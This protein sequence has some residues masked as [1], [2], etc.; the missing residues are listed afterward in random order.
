MKDCMKT[1][2]NNFLLKVIKNNIRDSLVPA[3]I[4]IAEI[5]NQPIDRSNMDKCFEYIR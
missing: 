1:L 2:S 3:P 5:D 4:L